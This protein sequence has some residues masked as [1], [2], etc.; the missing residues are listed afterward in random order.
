[1]VAGQEIARALSRVREIAKENGVAIVRS[2][3]VKRGDRELLVRTRWLQEIIQG[4]YMLVKPEALPGDSSIWY[5]HFWDFLELYLSFH[6]GNHYCLSAESSLDLH[7]GSSMIPN[8]VIVISAKG[9]GVPQEL[10]YNT[11]VFVYA[12][13]DKIPEERVVMRGVQVMTLPYALCKVSGAYFHKN[14]KESEIALRL[15]R[16]ASELTPILAKHGFK[17]A[18]SRLIGAYEFLGNARL[19]QELQHDLEEVGWKIKGENPF[20]HRRPILKLARLQSPY[21]GRIWSLWDSYRD[22]VIACFPKPK[23]LVKNQEGYFKKLSDVYQKD[24]YNSLSIEGY[25]VDEELIKRV[26]NNQWDPDFEVQDHA[27]RDALAA[28]GY[29]EAFQE[30]KKSIQ[31]LWQGENPGSIIEKDLKKWYQSLFAPNVRVGLMRPEDFL[32]YRKHPVYIRNS[33]HIPLPQEALLDAMETL[34]DCLKQEK[35]AAVR[36]VLGHYIFVYIHPYPDGNGRIGRFLMNAMFAS[37][38]YPWTIVQVKNRSRYIQTLE[39]VEVDQ[40]I[41]PFARFIVQELSLLE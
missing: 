17:A 21:V 3:Q 28:R 34:F 13:P 8:Q 1:M 40:N 15:I 19:S 37:G 39:T 33:R 36:A 29:F 2:Q 14:P 11:S 35:H 16:N 24:A 6:F 23:G 38:G 22:R 30:V 9:G 4:W 18:A 10:P 27:T 25:R 5:A 41:E 7:T 31:K 20:G 12:D 26:Q 32:G